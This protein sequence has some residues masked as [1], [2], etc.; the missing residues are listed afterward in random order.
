MPPKTPEQSGL[1]SG[2]AI[3][4]FHFLLQ[5]EP[6]SPVR[7]CGFTRKSGGV[8]ALC[9]MILIKKRNKRYIACSDCVMR[10]EIEANKIFDGD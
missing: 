4:T 1:Y 10:C 2:A 3:K 8:N 9:A 7:G 6:N 5:I